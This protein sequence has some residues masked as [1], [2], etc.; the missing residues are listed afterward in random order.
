V[1]GGPVAGLVF[2]NNLIKHNAYGI[3]GNGQAYGSGSLAYYA[4]TAV[5]LG[6]VLAS[7]TSVASRYPAG[8]QFPTVASFLASFVNPSAY[9]Y[10]LRP[11]SPYLAA[12]TDGQDL[13]PAFGMLP[14]AVA[15]L[16]PSRARVATMVW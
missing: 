9:D 1:T 10:R 15:P 4:P 8:N 5:V 11:T 16:P 3:F 7:D 6:N 14:A 2:T 13:G 12:G